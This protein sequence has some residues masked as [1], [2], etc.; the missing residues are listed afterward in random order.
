M[1]TYRSKETGLF[2]GRQA[3]QV[4]GETYETVE[5]PTSKDELIEFLNQLQSEQAVPLPVSDSPSPPTQDM[6]QP[7]DSDVT[8]ASFRAS[9]AEGRVD[10]DETLLAAPLDVSLRLLGLV[11]ERIREHYA[12]ENRNANRSQPV[13]REREHGEAVG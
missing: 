9:V 8:Y 6:P 1:K 10:L 5:V 13:R 2:V 11:T 4:D 12:K 3:D 7:S